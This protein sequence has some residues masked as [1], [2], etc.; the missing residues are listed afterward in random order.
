MKTVAI[1]GAGPSGITSAKYC[2]QYGLNPVV[3][4]INST[5]GGLWIPNSQIWSTLYCNFTKYSMAFSD[6]PWPEDLSFTYAHRDQIYEYLLKYIDK[7][8]LNKYFKL[9]SVVNSIKKTEA[10]KWKVNWTNLRTNEIFEKVFDYV[11]VA[12]GFNS[13]PNQPNIKNQPS[14]NGYVMHS[15]DYKTNHPN[16]KNKRVLV[17]GGSNS[18]VEIS[19]DLIGY[20][21]SVI[22]LFNR[23]FWVIPK[24]VPIK[25]KTTQDEIYIP[26]DFIFYTRNF[27]YSEE[28]KFKKYSLICPDQCNK[29]SCP[30]DLF[31]DPSKNIHAN[32]GI[33]E[34]FYSNV[35]NK[36]IEIKQGYIKEFF[37]NGVLLTDD[38]KI[39]V[40]V[41]L[42]CTGYKLSL[43]FFD[44]E[45]L[46]QLNFDK[47]NY[48]NPITLYKYTFHHAFPNLAFIFLTRGLFFAGL[49]LQSKWAAMILS[50]NRTLPSVEEIRLQI[51][52]N[53]LKRKN[54]HSAV[55]F[56]HGMYVKV[57]DE[58]AREI[59]ALPNY[60]IDPELF[61]MYWNY[62][63]LPSNF[64]FN[65]NKEE[66]LKQI[67]KIKELTKY[68]VPKD[69]NC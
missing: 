48:K 7:F 57:I 66:S 25:S 10:E 43:P 44:E 33:S 29:E 45:M 17:V 28:D 54:T 4:D 60:H 52:A 20:S 18:S 40:D 5:P 27:T 58:V 38:S 26:R 64:I 56:P 39:E 55:Q 67:E 41:V 47:D 21:K 35:K 37:E 63:A 8:D 62:L 16:L 13:Q 32:F 49:E 30:S 69:E 6:F 50:G 53:K 46:N 3:F 22:N 11:I 36:R 2:C 59:D 1:I 65:E 15:C 31:I 14:F 12:S 23:P 42:F 68:G 24:F 34:H 9:N 19:S 51:E 61:E